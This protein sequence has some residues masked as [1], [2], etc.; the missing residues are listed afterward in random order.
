MIGIH[1]CEKYGYP[2]L[3]R[4][5]ELEER[6]KDAREVS[7]IEF[8]GKYKPFPVVEVRIEFPVYRLRNGRTKTL[9]LEY[10]AK[11]PDQPD[12]LFTADHDA[13]AA[14]IAQNEILDRLVKD[15]NL[16]QEFSG[17]TQQTEPIIVTYDGIV[18]NG[19]RRLCVWRKLFYAD[20]DKYKYF[21]TIRVLV[22]P[23]ADE[24]ALD[25]LEEKLQTSK[26]FRADYSWHAVARRGKEKLDKE[27]G[28]ESKIAGP[29][30]LKTGGELKL[31]IEAYNYAE[32]YLESRNKKNY[33][34]EMDGFRYAFEAIAKTRKKIEGQELKELFEL[35]AF[36]KI[37]EGS[38]SG[39]LYIII[40]ELGENIEAVVAQLKKDLPIEN[41]E[42]ENIVESADDERNADPNTKDVAIAEADDADLLADNYD[43]DEVEDGNDVVDVI[44]RVKNSGNTS[45]IQDITKVAIDIAKQIKKDKDAA[46]YLFTQ[47]C[48]AETLLQSAINEGLIGDVSTEGIELH[49]KGILEGVNI[50]QRWLDSKK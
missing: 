38:D 13:L 20:P 46:N 21:Q 39:R 34:S 24:Q 32:Q 23:Q 8:M 30:G 4:I 48:K 26:T 31:L 36:Q 5:K 16:L 41:N 43:G 19:N 28:T 27:P 50:I 2:R 44:N 7:S 35:L 10:L 17:N 11:H 3:K 33:W 42:V 18:V 15:E 25:E 37:E 1:E 49:L 12:D 45:A 9:Q 29:L 14:Q 47:V 22:L 6:A 40:Q